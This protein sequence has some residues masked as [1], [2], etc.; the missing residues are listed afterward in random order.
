MSS[1]DEDVLDQND[2]NESESEALKRGR[3]DDMDVP[4]KKVKY[5]QK[6]KESYHFL[7]HLA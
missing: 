2:G 6:Y 7:A 4:K 1:A 5:I 3:N